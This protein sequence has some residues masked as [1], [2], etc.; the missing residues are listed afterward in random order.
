MHKYEDQKSFS[1]KLLENVFQAINMV[2]LT[3]GSA[4]KCETQNLR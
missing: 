3:A 2:S 1:L 4:P